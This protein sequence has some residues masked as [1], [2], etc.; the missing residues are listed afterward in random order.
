[1]IG[2]RYTTSTLTIDDPLLAGELRI[3]RL[4]MKEDGSLD[5]EDGKEVGISVTLE[6]KEGGDHELEL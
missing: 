3:I 4:R 2:N 6:W 5:D 1:M